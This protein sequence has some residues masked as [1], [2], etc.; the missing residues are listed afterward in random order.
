MFC[1][2]PL[3]GTPDYSTMGSRIAYDIERDPELWNVFTSVIQ[4]DNFSPERI[5]ELRRELIAEFYSNQ[6]DG[7]VRSQWKDAGNITIAMDDTKNSFNWAATRVIDMYLAV[8]DNVIY[9]TNRT[10]REAKANK[11]KE[12]MESLRTEW[13]TIIIN[14]V[15]LYQKLLSIKK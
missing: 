2:M 7:K 10:E 1:L 8:F 15:E 14:I 6:P 12:E 9:H 4:G 13:K 5:T 11:L 3:P